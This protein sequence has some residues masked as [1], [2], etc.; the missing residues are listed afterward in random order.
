MHSRY[1]IADTVLQHFNLPES[2]ADI[3]SLELEHGET[4]AQYAT[5][6]FLKPP[7]SHI[8]HDNVSQTPLKQY[9]QIKR[10]PIEALKNNNRENLE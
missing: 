8:K 5:V 1:T 4:P 2:V 9:S 10:L 3:T 6:A 7:A